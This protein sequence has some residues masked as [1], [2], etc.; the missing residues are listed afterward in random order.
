MH[1]N[2]EVIDLQL[3]LN[4]R[5]NFNSHHPSSD[6][7]LQCVQMNECENYIIS[8]YL[9]HTVNVLQPEIKPRLPVTMILA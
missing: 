6:G 7:V 3:R 4:L 1:F 9:S 2:L 8:L 5:V